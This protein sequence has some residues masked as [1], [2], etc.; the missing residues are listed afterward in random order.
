VAAGN[1]NGAALAGGVAR[2][3]LLMSAIPGVSYLLSAIPGVGYASTA[4]TATVAGLTGWN[5]QGNAIGASV[6]LVMGRVMEIFEK[7]YHFIIND[8]VYKGGAKIGL[9]RLSKGYASPL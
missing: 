2:D 7:G 6:D 4:A 1:A 5:F 9:E 3:S 8:Y